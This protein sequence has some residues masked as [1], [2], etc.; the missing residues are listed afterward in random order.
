MTN[1]IE[2]EVIRA[3]V[4]LTVPAC[5]NV[6]FGKSQV[7]YPKANGDLRN[8]EETPYNIRYRL[9]MD[10]YADDGKPATV[11]TMSEN[12][13]AALNETMCNDS[14]GALITFRKTSGGG[15]V[16]EKENE[17]IVHYMDAYEIIYYKNQEI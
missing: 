10:Y 16:E 1:R 11:V 7:I 15:F 5:T 12:V 8:I 6:F 9:T 3:V 14:N 2:S 13:R 17:K 4:Q